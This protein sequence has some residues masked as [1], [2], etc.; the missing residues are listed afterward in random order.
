[1][2]L[3]L[4]RRLPPCWQSALKP[5][6][7]SPYVSELEHFLELE[8]R[9]HVVVP[10]EDETLAAFSSCLFE[11]VAVCIVGQDPYPSP[12]HATG[13]AF[14]VPYGTEPPL[15]PPLRNVYA[16]LAR[17]VG[18][19]ATP[20]HGNLYGW[21]RQGVLL[22]N[23]V[24][25]ARAGEPMSHGGRGWEK[26]T[27]AAVSALSTKRSGLVFMLWGQHARRKAALIDKSSHLV[28]SAPHPSPA[29]AARGFMGASHFSAANRYLRAQGRG[30][31][32]DW[33]AHLTA[34]GEQPPPPP[35]PLA[36]EAVVEAEAEEAAVLPAAF[37]AVGEAALAAG[38]GA[39]ADD[40]GEHV[41]PTPV[42]GAAPHQW[43]KQLL[44]VERA[45]SSRDAPV[46]FLGCHTMG[47]P[48]EGGAP[49]RFQT[50]LALIL[51]ARTT[52]AAV[53]HAM[54]RLRTLAAVESLDGHLTAS[55]ISRIDAAFLL[56]ALDG[57]TYPKRKA[58]HVSRVATLLV[59]RYDG[60]VPADLDA[61]LALPGVGP[62][63]AHLF[64]QH[65]HGLTQGIAVDTHVHRIARRLGWT[66]GAKTPEAT[67]KQL[68]AWLPREHWRE[69]NPLLVGFGQQI[70]SADAPAC[71][72][73][74]LAVERLCP[75]I[76]VEP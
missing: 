41:P 58:E 26:F 7:A 30:V 23:S 40:R 73:C 62:K 71:R 9:S 1:M 42:P 66:R 57:V 2:R 52:D 46:D 19:P 11:D 29:A 51:S 63:V 5:E 72:S 25:T 37:E 69:I 33:G 14:S 55:A 16:E 24:L 36:T 6:L 4:A 61:V 44:A 15:P 12:S 49:F 50:L 76:G 35:P 3:A 28:L 38:R 39:A 60:D 65:G 8:R 17:D 75:Q 74:R 68:E 56:R 10:A 32:I 22:L 31:A 53:A 64:L 45:R 20:T 67:R 70:C 48:S 18:I 43:W 21:S 34:A 47:E 27:D 13:L 54:Q 59:E